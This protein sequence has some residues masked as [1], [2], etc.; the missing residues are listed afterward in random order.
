[1]TQAEIRRQN[2]RYASY[3][4]PVLWDLTKIQSDLLDESTALLEYVLGDEHSILFLVLKG[5]FQVFTLPGRDGLEAKVKELRRLVSTGNDICSEGVALYR[6]LVGPVEQLV[7]GKDL[8]II[9]DGILHYL[10]FA[11]LLTTAPEQNVPP[12]QDSES[13]S[14]SS[15][16]RDLVMPWTERL[17]AKRTID[18]GSLPYLIRRHT[19]RYAPSAS[20]AGRLHSAVHHPREAA[21]YDSQLAAFAD[22]L[23]ESVDSIASLDH[24]AP[25]IG[26]GTVRAWGHL[27]R[28][29]ST[30]DEVWG[31]AQRV[32][33]ESVPFG[34]RPELLDSHDIQIRSGTRATKDSIHA[35][36][37]DGKSYRFFHIATHGFLD[38]KNS[39]LSGL[40]LT[41]DERGD[42]YWQSFEICNSRI[43]SELV[44]LSACETGLG[45]LV[46]GEGVI[47]LA[48]AFMYAGAAS[49]CVSLWR[50]ADDS[51]AALMID[52]YK[53]IIA[54]EQK[55]Q[56]LRNAQLAMLSQHN[57]DR[58]AHPF[59]WAAFVQIGGT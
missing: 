20:I 31:I 27:T 22:P 7:A 40:I 56:A 15:V 16:M 2:P 55:S 24:D 4:D 25:T 8:L 11:V 6:D 1:L 54:G 46:S 47:G 28:L 12:T 3:V 53:G 50:V 34:S 19:I 41:P 52:F 9:P 51:T 44:V 45:R 49:V 32:S 13:G 37:A 35:L 10:P 5:D 39:H 38:T 23:T 43:E 57:N 29:P 26:M 42:R 33:P 18:Y 48:R 14:W 30:L 36:T 58:Y 17:F 21:S 59:Y